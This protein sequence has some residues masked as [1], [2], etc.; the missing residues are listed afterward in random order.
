MKNLF[1]LLTLFVSSLLISQEKNQ[2]PNKIFNPEQEAILQTKQL[3]LR[4]DLTKVQEEKIISILKSHLIDG[5]KLRQKRK[6]GM[7]QEEA[8]D[9]R[10]KFLDH[11]KSLQE[12]LKSILDEKQYQEWKGFQGLRN[13]KKS[14]QRR[15]RPKR[16]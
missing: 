10:I 15:T 9:L 3:S 7:T 6:K 5:I 2:E 14:E 16:E 8:F 11:Q 13:N 4:L 12:N 1:T